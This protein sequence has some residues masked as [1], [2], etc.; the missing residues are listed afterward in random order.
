MQMKQLITLFCAAMM[1]LLCLTA[2][3]ESSEKVVE[4]AD[5][6]TLAENMVAAD[7]SFPDMLIVTDADDSAEEHFAS[8]SQLD[9]T[10]VAHY[11]IA[12]SAE[13]KADE[14]VVIAM[15]NKNE[16][17]AAKADLDQHVTTRRNMY[18]TYDPSQEP[19]VSA[20]K[21]F[22]SGYYAVLIVSDR[23]DA[24]QAAFDGGSAAE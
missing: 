24:V 14:I 8:V 11:L 12:Y 3:G 21:V 15:K 6:K 17:S 5:M 23:A 22:V 9:Y 13:G 4:Y 16:V 20:A 7:S 1:M 10:K 19:R 18:R 2:C